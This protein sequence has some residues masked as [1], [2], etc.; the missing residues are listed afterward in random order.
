MGFDTADLDEKLFTDYKPAPGEWSARYD[1]LGHFIVTSPDGWDY[2]F[3]Y[4][5]RKVHDAFLCSTDKRKFLD[6]KLRGNPKYYMN[7]KWLPKG[8]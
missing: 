3:Y 5:P 2:K 1:E 8:G 7:A 4:V 6:K